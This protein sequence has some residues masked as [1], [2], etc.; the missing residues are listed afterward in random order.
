MS[1]MYSF[2]QCKLIDTH[3]DVCVCVYTIPVKLARARR[4]LRMNTTVDDGTDVPYAAR[5][6]RGR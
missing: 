3:D 1:M 6:G 4:Q 2:V 5:R